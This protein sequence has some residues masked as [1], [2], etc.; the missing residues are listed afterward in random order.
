MHTTALNVEDPYLKEV[1]HYIQTH[2]ATGIFSRE[3]EQKVQKLR[4]DKYIRSQSMQLEELMQPREEKGIQQG[5]AAEKE[6]ICIAL[7]KKNMDISFIQ[8]VTGMDE[9]TIQKIARE[10]GMA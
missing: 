9:K 5:S 8:D 10:S 7:L 1:H 2:E 4:K 6:K 3:I